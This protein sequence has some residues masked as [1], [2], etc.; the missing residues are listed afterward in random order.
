MSNS[1]ILVTC[2]I[3]IAI[4]I[5]VSFKWSVNMGVLAMAFAFVIGCLMQGQ[6]VNTVFGFW[7]DNLIFF[8]I[9]SALFF[10]FARENGTLDVFGSK[11]L[12]V[13]R[14]QVKLLPWVFFVLAGVLGFLGSGPS[15]LLLL[16]PIGFPIALRAGIDPIVIGFSIAMGYNCGTMNPWTGSGVVLYGLVEANGMDTATAITTYL[17]TYSTFL[18]SQVICMA[19]VIVY[20]MVFR[21]KHAAKGAGKGRP[22]EILT[23]KPADYTPV[24]KKTFVLIVISFLLMV[25]PSIWNTLAPADSVV[26]KNFVALCKPQ[27]ILVIFALF[28]TLLKLGD[29]KKVISRVPVGTILMIAGVSFLMSIAKEA[30][31]IEVISAAFGSGIPKILVAPLFCILGG[32]LSLFASGT[33]VVLPLLFPMVPA[34]AA[35]TG[36]NPVALYAAAQIGALITPFSPFSSAGAQLIALAPN[37]ISESLVRRQFVVAL[38]T[39]LFCALLTLLGICNIFRI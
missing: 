36:L 1:V 22:L 18:I 5:I 39:L 34:L 30:G 38:V 6:S 9:A 19:A 26:F 3:A 31:M 32:V 24:Q 16:A 21:H 17:M 28:A 20:Y 8:M 37:S 10:G 27:A 2:V 33:S 25:I 14:R 13:F 11:V 15:A 7:P 12:W 29:A 23:E 35:A 4:S